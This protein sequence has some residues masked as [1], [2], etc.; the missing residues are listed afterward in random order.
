[1]LDAN[2]STIL[3]LAGTSP[4]LAGEAAR[5][6]GLSRVA[7][8]R[9]IKRLAD[10]GYLTR[11]GNGTRQTYSPGANRFW[12]LTQS[13]EAISAAGGESGIWEAHVARVASDLRPNVA[14]IANICFTEMLNNAIDH[15]GASEVCMGAHLYGGRLQMAVMDNGVGIFR[16]IAQASR[17]FDIRLAVLELAKGKYTTAHEGHSGMGIFV[18]SRMLDGFMVHSGG[19]SFAPK[20]PQGVDL[21]FSWIAPYRYANGTVVLMDLD[22]ATDRTA[23]SVYEQYFFPDEVGGDAFHTTEIPVKHAQLSSQLTSRSQGKWVMERA[24]QFKTVIL[25]FEGVEM[26]GQAFVDEVFRVF[27]TAHPEVQLV[28]RHVSPDVA[29]MIKLFAPHVVW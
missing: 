19:L 24:P 17:L 27:A 18:A 3:A 9:R 29:R 6:T 7:V 8:S 16:K 23:Q 5:V 26:V 25:D 12:T 22:T 15:S 4:Q 1:M 11:H 10:S 13:L 28:P 20:S 14:N 2:D 21:S